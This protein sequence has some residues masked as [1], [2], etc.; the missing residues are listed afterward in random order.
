[1]TVEHCEIPDYEGKINKLFLENKKK[2]S[3]R[4]RNENVKNLFWMR[5][6]ANSLTT[7]KRSKDFDKKLF[8]IFYIKF[9]KE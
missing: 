1:M 2:S 3:W 6:Q 9:H 7:F 5:Y 8:I 4:Y